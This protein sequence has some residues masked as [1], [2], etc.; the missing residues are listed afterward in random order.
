V[1][2]VTALPLKIVDVGVGLG[3]VMVVSGALIVDVTW[4]VVV[5]AVAVMIDTG[6]VE[7]NVSED[8]ATPP[9][10]AAR[11]CRARSSCTSRTSRFL[12]TFKLHGYI[13]GL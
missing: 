6:G 2:E 11:R 1:V 7:V 12:L 5:S 10:F 3:T 4:I 9:G 13:V 8:P